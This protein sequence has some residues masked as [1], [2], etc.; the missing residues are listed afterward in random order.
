MN[1]KDARR[2]VETL[3]RKNNPSEE[4]LFLFTDA[5]CFLIKKNNTVEMHWYI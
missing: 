5:M 4:E 3:G 1:E 2:I